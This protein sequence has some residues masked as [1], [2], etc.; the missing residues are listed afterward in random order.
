MGF[1]ERFQEM[2]KEYKHYLDK[3]VFLTL[4]QH[5]VKV[6]FKSY[7]QIAWII[8]TLFFGLLFTLGNRSLE[9]INFLL[10]FF[11]FFGSIIM[12]IVV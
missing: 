11:V 4:Y 2:L 3:N 12:S 9:T 7:L 8:I 1:Y 6:G 10:I 5:E